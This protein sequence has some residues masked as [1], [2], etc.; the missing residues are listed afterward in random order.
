M[1]LG[2]QPVGFGNYGEERLRV[3]GISCQCLDL[4]LTLPT[5]SGAQGEQKY[6]QKPIANHLRWLKLAHSGVGLPNCYFHLSLTLPLSPLLACSGCGPSRG[7]W[8]VGLPLHG[9]R[10]SLSLSLSP[11]PLHPE[12]LAAPGNP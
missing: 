9:P 3:L 6:E 12:D 4:R 5:G 10:L 2:T 1:D 7:S 11:S 8:P